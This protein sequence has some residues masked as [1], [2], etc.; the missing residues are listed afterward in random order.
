SRRPAERHSADRAPRSRLG[1]GASWP[2]DR[3][4]TAEVTMRK[5]VM[6]LVLIAG[7][8]FAG[9]VRAAPEGTAFA[10]SC[11]DVL[12]SVAQDWGEADFLA[13]SK[14]GQ[15]RVGGKDGRAITAGQFNYLQGQLR[16]ARDDCRTGRLES[17]MNRIAAMRRILNRGDERPAVER[18]R[19]TPVLGEVP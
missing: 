9:G 14:P 10:A 16:L 18:S 11:T 6:L 15:A 3:R 2:C 1:G 5:A 12:D 7:F 17:A 4:H 13:P 19:A 8:V